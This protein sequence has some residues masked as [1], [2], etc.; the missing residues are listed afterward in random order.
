MNHPACEG[1]LFNEP[2]GCTD[3]RTQFDGCHAD[4]VK[5]AREQRRQAEADA[6]DFFAANPW[7]QGVSVGSYHFTRRF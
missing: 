2:Q 1:C 4:P 7:C 3:G 5:L 6:Q